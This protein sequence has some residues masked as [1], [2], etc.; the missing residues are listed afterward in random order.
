MQRLADLQRAPGAAPRGL[1]QLPLKVAN[2]RTFDTPE[3]AGM[4]FLEVEASTALNRVKGMPFAWSINPYRG[5]S[6]ACTYCVGGE[7]PILMADGRTR[8]IADLRIGDRIYG[9]IESR[10]CRRYAVTEVLDHWQTV[11]QAY[12]VILADGTSIIASGDHRF[13]SDRGWKHVKGAEHGPPQ[14]PHLTTDDRLIGTGA[15]EEAPKQ[16]ANYRRGYLHGM[17]RGEGHTASEACAR[18]REYRLRE[19]PPYDWPDSPD[20]EWAKGFLAGVFDATGSYS[21]GVLRIHNA[22]AVVAERVTSSLKRFCIPHVVESPRS[23][24][25]RGVRVC[26]GPRQ[27][28]RFFHLTDPAIRRKCSLG[29]RAVNGPCDLRVEAIEPLG[30]ELP[31]Y[32]ITTGTGDFI[33]NGAISH[34]CFARPTHAYLNLSPRGDFE[35]TVVV[36]TNVAQVLRRELAKPS[37]KGERVAMGTNTDPYQRCEGRYSLMP[38]IISNLAESRTPFSILTKGTM[39]TRDLGVLSEAAEQV[40]VTAAMTIGMLED[41]LW[42]SIEPGTPSPAA[43]LSAVKALNEA[44]LPTGV[45]LAPI[46]PGLNDDREQLASLVDRAA[47]AGA[48]HVT[49]I[50]LHLR[51]G[52][53]EVFWPWLEQEHPELV[54]RYHSLYRRRSQAAEEYRKGVTSFVVEQRKL[55]WHRHGNPKDAGVHGEQARKTWTARSGAFAED[56]AEQLK[57]L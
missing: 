19:R 18:V 2:V 16:D 35:K 20:D 45:M 13:L 32:D 14:R 33:A 21:D 29:G 55:A 24:G 54:D 1:P 25:C 42:R 48:T 56:P 4:K 22:A 52:V 28:L 49:P 11:K 43:R 6:H 3:F 40:P 51:P 36:K 38:E 5:C 10:A 37:W 7:T 27:H 34:N 23:N 39:I 15:F 57:L 31:L 41:K 12:R 26:A 17:I 8:P 53:R 47:A 30:V 44:G 50:V 46:M 9:T